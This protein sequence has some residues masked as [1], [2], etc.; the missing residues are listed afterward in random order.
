MLQLDCIKI[1]RKNEKMIQRI[2]MRPIVI[3]TWNR[4]IHH[5]LLQK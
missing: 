3:T 4:Y 5:V 1:K 2:N